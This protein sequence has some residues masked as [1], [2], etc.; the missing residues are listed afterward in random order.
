MSV[1]GAE[2]RAAVQWEF[3]TVLSGV[4]QTLLDSDTFGFP[5]CSISF[6]SRFVLPA[7]IVECSKNS[8]H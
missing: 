3:L 7:L 5:R 8:A 4:N 6:L 1:S 2:L